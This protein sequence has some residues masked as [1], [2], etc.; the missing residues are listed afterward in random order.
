MI[1]KTNIRQHNKGIREVVSAKL[2]YRAQMC[3]R[4]SVTEMTTNISSLATV[5]AVEVG[6]TK[7]LSWLVPLEVNVTKLT[8]A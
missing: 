4:N 1:Q 3:C 8:F 5:V 2:C 7:L 6:H